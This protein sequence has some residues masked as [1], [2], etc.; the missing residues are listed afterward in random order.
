MLLLKMGKSETVHKKNVFNV[1]SNNGKHSLFQKLISCSSHWRKSF[2]TK[3]DYRKLSL[4][5]RQ[6]PPAIP[7]RSQHR[8]PGAAPGLFRGASSGCRITGS[9]PTCSR[10]LFITSV[11]LFWAQH[12]FFSSLKV[13]LLPA[14]TRINHF[15]FSLPSVP[16]SH[17]L[18]QH[19]VFIAT[20]YGGI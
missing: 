16:N 3:L 8:S 18:Q 14:P 4:G 11:P 17:D 12:T 15:F 2:K 19:R 6:S 20:S 13:F 1:T 10:S 9:C 7:S 5:V